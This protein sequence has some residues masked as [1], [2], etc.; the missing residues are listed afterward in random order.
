MHID[1]NLEAYLVNENAE[2]ADALR[3]LSDAQKRIVFTV[4]NYFRL[5]GA[6]TDGDFRRWLLNQSDLNLKVPVSQVANRN[7]ISCQDS[8]DHSKIAERLSSRVQCIPI[9]DAER[10]V[11]SIASIKAPDIAFGV[12]SINEESPAFVAPSSRCATSSRFTAMQAMPPT[13]RKTSGRSMCSI[14]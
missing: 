7:V 3:K 9:V 10:R 13:I 6:L 11:I 12:R 4:D 14:C 8:D 1:K 2:I 5:T